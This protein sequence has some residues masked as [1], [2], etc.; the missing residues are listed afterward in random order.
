[1]L[2]ELGIFQKVKVGFILV[3]HTH[4][5]IDQMFNCFAVTLKRNNVGILPS[6][7]QAIKRAYMLEPIVHTLQETIDM[8]RFI[9]GSHGEEKCIEQLND[10]SVQPQFC[11]KNIDAKTLI[12]GKKYSTSV[13]LGPSSGFSSKVHPKLENICIKV[14]VIVIS[15]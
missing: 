8:Q 4:D 14:I 15:D 12:Y 3:G 6:L 11:I 10:I 13:E 1:M 2:V 7:I 9:Q 5:H